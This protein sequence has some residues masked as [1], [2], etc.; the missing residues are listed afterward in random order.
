MRRRQNGNDR[1]VGYSRKMTAA[2]D[3]DQPI[4]TST[5]SSTTVC[6][7]MM[8]VIRKGGFQTTSPGRADAN[9]TLPRGF[10]AGE[11]QRL[12]S[13]YYIYMTAKA[14][15]VKIPLKGEKSKIRKCVLDRRI[16]RGVERRSKEDNAFEFE[17]LKRP[18]EID[19]EDKNHGWEIQL[20]ISCASQG[21]PSH[22]LVKESVSS[23]T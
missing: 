12:R 21:R 16:K 18:V 17:G 13:L 22:A 15:V 23:T 4:R 11:C 5:M 2:I 8:E 20:R 9:H 19:E 14:E 3:V 7:G 10:C 1:V 6:D